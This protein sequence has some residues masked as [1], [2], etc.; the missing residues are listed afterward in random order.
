MVHQLIA[1][2]APFPAP[3]WQLR[4][5]HNSSSRGSLFWPPGAPGT[6][7][8]QTSMEANFY[9][10]INGTANV[11]KP[12]NN[13]QDIVDQSIISALRKWEEEQEFITVLSYTESLRP[14]LAA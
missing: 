9:R 6:H 14:A 3:A 12:T 4:A 11:N 13:G 2:T 10:H 1:P 8:A 5:D 7:A